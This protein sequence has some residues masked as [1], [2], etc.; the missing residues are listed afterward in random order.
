MLGTL[1]ISAFAQARGPGAAIAAEPATPARGG[2]NGMYVRPARPPALQRPCDT[3]WSLKLPIA[4][5]DP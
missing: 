2:R 3:N 5:S 4:R 1:S